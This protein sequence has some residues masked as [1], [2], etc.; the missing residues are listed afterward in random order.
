MLNVLIYYQKKCFTYI[1]FHKNCKCGCLLDKKVCNDLQKWN[2]NKCRCECLIIKKCKI[3]YSLNINN[4]R[5]ERKKRLIDSEECDVETDV[6][7]NDTKSFFKNK[8]LIKKVENCKS[9]ID[10][11]IL[12]LLVSLILGGIIFILN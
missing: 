10:I 6:I 5:C 4:R 12:F 2:K 8:T 11:R 7:R 3:G 9:F 1:S